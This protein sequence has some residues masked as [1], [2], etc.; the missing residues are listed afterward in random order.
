MAKVFVNTLDGERH[1]LDQ[2]TFGS[3]RASGRKF[4]NLQEV[5]DY[6]KEHPAKNPWIRGGENSNQRLQ[7]VPV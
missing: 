3:I 1:E 7:L 4:T 6:A 2:E 5:R